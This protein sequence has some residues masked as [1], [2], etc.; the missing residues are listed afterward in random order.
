[1][2]EAGKYVVVEKPMATKTTEAQQ[3]VRAARQKGVKL[4]IH[5]WSSRYSVL[6]RHQLCGS[7]VFFT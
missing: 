4:T 7:K 3:M 6:R 1:M 5:L 2:T